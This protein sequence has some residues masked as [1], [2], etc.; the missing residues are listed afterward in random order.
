L[1]HR[2]N[3][4]LRQEGIMLGLEG[5]EYGTEYD[6]RYGHSNQKFHEGKALF[7]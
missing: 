7:V 3:L 1:L 4:I 6:Q 5:E 2:T